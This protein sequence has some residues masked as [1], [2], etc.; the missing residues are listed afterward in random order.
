MTPTKDLTTARHLSSVPSGTSGNSG[1]PLLPRSTGHVATTSRTAPGWAA[2]E[3]PGR[4]VAAQ[5]PVQERSLGVAGPQAWLFRTWGALKPR[6]QFLPGQSHGPWEMP[7]E[8]NAAACCVAPRAHLR[9]PAPW[10]PDAVVLQSVRT[11]LCGASLRPWIS[12]GPM[13][14]TRAF[15]HRRDWLGPSQ[16]TRA[17]TAGLV[18]QM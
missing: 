10:P 9:S 12:W 13:R 11:E 1:R 17:T 14:T 15:L 2:K 8:R 5:T 6:R 7:Q 16:G 4:P 3:P 18:F